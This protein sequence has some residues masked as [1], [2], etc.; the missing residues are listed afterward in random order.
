MKKRDIYFAFSAFER[1]T[2]FLI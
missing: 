2:T 1:N